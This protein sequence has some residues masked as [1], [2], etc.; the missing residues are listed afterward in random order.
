VY[1]ITISGALTSNGGAPLTDPAGKIGAEYKKFTLNV[2]QPNSTPLKVVS[3][4]TQHASVNIGNNTTIAQ[5]DTIAVGF[6][7]AVDFLMLNSNTVQLLAGPSNKPVPAVIAY[8]PTPKAVFITPTVRLAPGT[9][10][11][12]RIA[13]TISD[14]QTFPNPDKSHTLG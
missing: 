9:K 11:T 12:I 8:S 3:V 10:Y 6:N 1:L 7:K 4:T 5:P 2:T 13:G 14:N